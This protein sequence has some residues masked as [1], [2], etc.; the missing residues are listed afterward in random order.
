MWKNRL[1]EGRTAS[2]EISRLLSQVQGHNFG[3]WN[4]EGGGYRDKRGTVC[5]CAAAMLSCPLSTL[6][7][8]CLHGLHSVEPL[9]SDSSCYVLYFLSNRY[10]L[11]GLKTL[12]YFKSHIFC[13][14]ISLFIFCK[15]T[16][17]SVNCTSFYILYTG[18]YINFLLL[19]VRMLEELSKSLVFCY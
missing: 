2:T 9:Q 16:F 6:L 4:R 10:C 17:E 18:T 8:S 14:L 12:L 3:R 19:F 1:G 11:I 7:G 5:L 13:L 15:L